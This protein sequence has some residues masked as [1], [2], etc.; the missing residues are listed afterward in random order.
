MPAARDDV[1]VQ[2]RA[3]TLDL[4]DT[5]WP[6]APVAAGISAA[7]DGW[8]AEYAPLTRASH[9]PAAIPGLLQ[10]I[11]LEHPE[12]AH[13]L[14]AVRREVLRRSLTAAGEDPALAE[15]AFDVVFAARQQVTLYPD[16]AA[17]LDRLAARVPLLALTD[18]NADL[19]LTG[20]SR[21]FTAGLVNARDVGVPKPDVR[22]FRAASERLGLPPEQILHAGDNLELDVVGALAAGFQAA[23]VQRDLAG[24]APDGAVTVATLTELAAL[25]ER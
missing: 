18:G 15:A 22:M 16:V 6:F 1:P 23:W 12:I 8:L 5:L 21:W 4:D 2:I 10:A 17:A 9:D 25:L 24:S 20:V 13:D 11:R 3:V 14:G 7:L 19:E